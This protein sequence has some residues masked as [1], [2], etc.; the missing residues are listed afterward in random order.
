MS[1]TKCHHIFV[2][3]FPL[4]Y[5]SGV[6][7]PFNDIVFENTLTTSTSTLHTVYNH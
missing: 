2:A 6:L 1:K 4:K 3:V 5:P 7:I